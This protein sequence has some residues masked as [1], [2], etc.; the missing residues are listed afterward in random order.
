MGHTMTVCG[1]SQL[2][3]SWSESGAE[4]PNAPTTCGRSSQRRRVRTEAIAVR[5]LRR[6]DGIAGSLECH[7]VARWSGLRP[8][9]S[10]GREFRRG[11]TSV[12][13]APRTILMRTLI[14]SAHRTLL[15]TFFYRHL[16]EL[17]MHNCI[18]IAQPPLFR[19]DIGKERTYL[20]DDAAFRG[21]RGGA[22]SCS[23]RSEPLQGAR[24][25]GL[26]GA[27]HHHHEL[28]R[29]ATCSR[30]RWPKPRSPTR[31]SPSSWVTTSTGESSSSRRTP[32]TS[33]SSMCEV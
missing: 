6:T 19:A 12:P 20:K 17:V 14:G 13:L 30:C 21:V 28:R 26:G 10:R 33:A 27:R 18:Y 1:K 25:D 9:G 7:A 8:L 32:R 23:H 2:P 22:R 5:A 16:P 11:L 15:L 29:R 31:C 4:A 3:T 24:R